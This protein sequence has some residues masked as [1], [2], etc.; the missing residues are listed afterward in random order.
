MLRTQSLRQLD[1]M[2][3]SWIAWL[4][5]VATVV[6]SGNVVC[7]AEGVCDGPA[8]VVPYGEG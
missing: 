8:C 1:G 5:L 6:P 7:S 4:G 2:F 3:S